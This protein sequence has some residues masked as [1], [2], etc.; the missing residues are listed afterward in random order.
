[1]NLSLTA[2]FRRDATQ[3]DP[4]RGA[5]RENSGGGLAMKA[6]QLQL[7]L[8]A[9]EFV[10]YLTQAGSVHITECLWFTGGTDF[11]EDV[12]W[13]RIEGYKKIDAYKI[14]WMSDLECLRWS[15]A[16]RYSV[17]E[18]SDVVAVNSPYMH[19]I[20]SAYVPPSKLALL[21]D[22]MDT[23]W[24]VPGRKTRTLYA[25][26]QVILEKGI[27]DI[28][29][30][31]NALRDTD[32]E[33]LFIGS[34][35]TWGLELKPQVSH[36]LDREVSAVADRRIKFGK[37]SD[38][39]TAAQQSWLFASFARFESFGYAMVEALLG[40]CWVFCINHRV[41]RD[42]PVH[43][44]EDVTACIGTLGE[45]IKTRSESTVNEAGRQF[46]I[47]NYSLSVFRRQFMDIVGRRNFYG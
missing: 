44:F 1:M 16:E 23:E 9:L 38:V 33:S 19:D 11:S 36:R 31:F 24:V 13:E 4:K 22:P 30:I 17:F 15:G 41:Y 43:A 25:C 28:V 5:S 46:V 2:L 18:A 40:G 47:D 42:R 7:A 35:E 10:P 3:F 12:M 21:T 45:F 39:R 14:L 20:L 32:V 8:P 37:R 34:P 29:A 26:S 6:Q 27:A